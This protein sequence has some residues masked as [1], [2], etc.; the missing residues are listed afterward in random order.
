MVRTFTTRLVQSLVASVMA[1]AVVACAPALAGTSPTVHDRSQ[2]A[3][4]ARDNLPYLA[5]L[6]SAPL[7]K[8][9]AT[10]LGLSKLYATSGWMLEKYP[11]VGTYKAKCLVAISYAGKYRERALRTIPS[12]EI[13][14]FNRYGKPTYRDT[15]KTAYAA[16]KKALNSRASHCR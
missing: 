3:T 11:Y 8:R 14:V 6:D 10:A 9:E 16:I 13:T 2:S 7:L 15:D 12:L 5:E 4:S 1:L